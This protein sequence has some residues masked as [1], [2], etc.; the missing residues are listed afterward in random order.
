ML[1]DRASK[2]SADHI[3]RLL[4]GRRLQAAV[5]PYERAGEPV[6]GSGK[7]MGEPA[8]DAGMPPVDWPVAGRFH[9]CH[10]VVAYVHIEAAADAA[11]AASGAGDRLDGAR[12]TK[13]DLEESPGGAGIDTAAA[14]DAGRV[15]PPIAGTGH[16]DGVRAAARQR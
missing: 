1:C 11:V 6:G 5:A 9:C 7:C 3:Q 15:D 14:G 2:F 8:L 4:P 10:R 16:Q 12:I 13:T